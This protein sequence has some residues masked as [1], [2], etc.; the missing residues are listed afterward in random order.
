MRW[1][2]N[3]PRVY[4]VR[5]ADVTTIAL[6]EDQVRAAFNE[7]TLGRGL[8]YLNQGRVQRAVLLPGALWG[9]VAGTDWDPYRVHVTVEGGRPVSRCSCPVGHQCKHGV[10]VAM[11][12]VRDPGR[13]QDA[14]ETLD[15]LGDLDLEGL[16]RVVRGLVEEDPSLLP[17]VRRAVLAEAP[18]SEERRDEEL[19]RDHWE[20]ARVIVSRFN[21]F[22]GGPESEEEE[23]YLHLGELGDL[24]EAG[25]IEP[26]GRRDLLDGL[27]D[28][29]L[30]HNSGFDDALWELVEPLCTEREDWELVVE[31]LRTG[32]NEWDQER[33]MRVLMD[34]LGD[35]EAYLEMR[36]ADLETGHDYWDLAAFHLARGDE[37]RAVEVAEEG[38]ARGTGNLSWLLEFLFDRYS[39][40]GDGEAVERVV[41][42]AVERGSHRREMLDRLFEYRDARDDYEGARDALLEA[43]GHVRYGSYYPEYERMR[44]YLR[45]DDWERVEPDLLDTMRRENVPDYLRAL[46]DKGEK[47][48]VMECLMDPPEDGRWYSSPRELDVFAVQLAGEFPEEVIEYY[49]GRARRRIPGG[50]RGTYATAADY[51]GRARDIY[52]DLPGGEE[53]WERRFADLRA[54]FSKRPAFLDEV[55]HL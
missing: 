54:E 11:A 3:A 31:R 42:T 35:E 2:D 47:R 29:Y 20:E 37:A 36:L 16:V 32:G 14:G 41:R 49:W 45:P 9:E 8:S 33:V 5:C 52:F 27:L 51:L 48:K 34:R 7:R 44:D 1:F 18:V 43:L 50:N 39:A 23:A 15:K 4:R 17:R 38:I 21:E 46:M 26:E 13:F 28:E 40:A 55:S 6:T 10:A 25:A 30:H 24:L 19:A 22:G 53:R 12:W